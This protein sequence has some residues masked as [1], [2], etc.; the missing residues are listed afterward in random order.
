[1]VMV[2]ADREIV[3]LEP[4]NQVLHMHGIHER[5][6]CRSDTRVAKETVTGSVVYYGLKLNVMNLKTN[7]YLNGLLSGVWEKTAIGVGAEWFSGIWKIVRMACGVW[8]IF[9]GWRGP[10]IYYTYTQC[11]CFQR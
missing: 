7:I 2:F 11:S 9:F 1:M 8:G 4:V 5:R 3:G 6:W 10:K